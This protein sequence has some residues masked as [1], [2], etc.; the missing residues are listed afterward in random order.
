[1]LLAQ[2]GGALVLALSSLA[3]AFPLYLGALFVWGAFG[4]VAM[5]MSRTIMQE[6]APDSQRGRVMSFYSFSF[7]GAGPVG[8]LLNGFLADQVGPR[9]ALL[10][11]ASAMFT[12][13]VMIA[14]RSTL[15]H[16]GAGPPAGATDP[17]G[18][19]VAADSSDAFP[20]DRG[21]G[22]R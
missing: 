21:S 6:Q 14:A 5:T 11:C 22:G 15:W 19:D 10:I 1:L 8:A 20:V 13:V 18:T 4:G 16:L 2:A 3:P 17:V 7:L 9:T 12:I